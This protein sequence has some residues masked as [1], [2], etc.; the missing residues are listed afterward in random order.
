MKKDLR[1]IRLKRRGIQIETGHFST[2]RTRITN[3]ECLKASLHSLGIAVKT[4]ADVRGSNGQTVRS[5]IVAVLEGNYDVGWSVNSDGNF[6]LIVNFWSLAKKYNQTEF[7]NS[8]NQR[9]AAMIQG[10]KRFLG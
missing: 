6:D 9:Y 7:I 2:L 3:P 10:Y 8:I 4:Y 1:N 5:D